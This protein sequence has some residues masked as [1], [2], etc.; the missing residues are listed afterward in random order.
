MMGWQNT[1]VLQKMLDTCDADGNIDQCPAVTEQSAIDIHAKITAGKCNFVI[2]DEVA[3][4]NCDGP[5]QG[6]CGDQ[7]K[8]EHDNDNAS[9]EHHSESSPAPAPMAMPS[10]GYIAA[11]PSKASSS[12]VKVVESSKSPA[13]SPAPAPEQPAVGAGGKVKSR[14]LTTIGG[15]VF[16]VEYEEVTVTKVHTVFIKRGIEEE[17]KTLTATATAG[18]DIHNILAADHGH[19]GIVHW[20]GA[21]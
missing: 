4:E 9:P 16:A 5:R 3:K 15:K 12:M 13:M 17:T 2:P 14:P 19:G 20:L 10:N 7:S 21:L 8:H 1:G 18:P 6:F 11:H